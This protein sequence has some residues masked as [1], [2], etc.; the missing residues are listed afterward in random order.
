MASVTDNWETKTYADEIGANIRAA[1]VRADLTQRQLA[2]RM[3]ALGY[4]WQNSLVAKLEASNRPLLAAEVL[5]LCLALGCSMPTLMGASEDD[6]LIEVGTGVIGSITVRRLATGMM[7][8]F[9]R[10]VIWGDSD[11]VGVM[12]V[13]ATPGPEGARQHEVGVRM[14]RA[15]Q[16]DGKGSDE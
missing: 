7:T 10:A 13:F 14:V 4:N 5:G 15:A 16:P 1:R 12:Y 6:H 11:D 9:S 8:E 2:A 3:R